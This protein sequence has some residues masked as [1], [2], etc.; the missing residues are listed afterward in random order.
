M[1]PKHKP[2]EKNP[3]KEWFVFTRRDRN[4]AFILLA[5]LAIIIVLPW[6][7]PSEKLDMHVDATLQAELDKY[8]N[9]SAP[10]SARPF[11]AAANYA[12]TSETDTATHELFYFDPNT[13]SEGG[14]IQLGLSPK[15]AHT[16]INYRGKGGHFKTPEDI[17][18]IYSLSKADA[19]RIVPYIRIAAANKQTT[20]AAEKAQTSNEPKPPYRGS[21]LKKT[22]INAAA[23]EDW[24][25][26]PG[27]GDVLANRII[28]FRASIG[29]FKSVDQVAKTYGLSDSVFQLIKPYLYMKH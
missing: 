11:Y 20:P 13:L 5:I 3:W 1:I 14:F 2:N 24:K 27:I 15:T 29:G 12:D 23:A 19:D 8:R 25:A 9:D 22:E 26:F 6:F 10:E 7:L 21:Q 18:K 16:I 4:A 28:K 17:R